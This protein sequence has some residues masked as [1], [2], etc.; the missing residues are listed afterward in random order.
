MTFLQTAVVRVFAIATVASLFPLAGASIALADD[1]YSSVVLHGQ[2]P[3]YARLVA[4]VGL[5]LGNQARTVEGWIKTSD[6]QDQVMLDYGKDADIGHEW[7]TIIGQNRL[8]LA[9][10]GARVI[11]S[12]PNITDGQWHH[13]AIVY[14]GVGNGAVSGCVEIRRGDVS[15]GVKLSI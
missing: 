11:W 15:D 4:P 9:L 12:A 14:R 2:P 3:E 10:N 7:E 5:P 1:D 6:G 13:I 8:W